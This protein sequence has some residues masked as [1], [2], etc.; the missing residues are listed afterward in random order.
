MAPDIPKEQCLP[1]SW[2]MGTTAN[3]SDEWTFDAWLYVVFSDD[4]SLFG[5]KLGQ[6]LNSQNSQLALDNFSYTGKVAG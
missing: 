2:R 1:C 5:D 6:D 4:T 3:G